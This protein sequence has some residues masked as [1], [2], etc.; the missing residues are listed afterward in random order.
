MEQSSWKSAENIKSTGW[1]TTMQICI[2][3][4][5]SFIKDK[6]ANWVFIFLI[7][8]DLYQQLHTQLESN[9]IVSSYRCCFRCAP[10]FIYLGRIFGFINF[11]EV[12]KTHKMSYEKLY[13]VMI[14]YIGHFN[15]LAMQ[16]IMIHNYVI[17][18][19]FNIIHFKRVS[20]N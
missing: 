17:L 19:V 7:F 16:W 5:K 6:K 12:V 10:P 20:H 1:V 14:G 4:R 11:K 2:W 3:C 15:Q 18:C 9:R 13:R 8:V